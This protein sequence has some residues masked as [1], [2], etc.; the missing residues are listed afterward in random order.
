MEEDNEITVDVKGKVC[1]IPVLETAKAA[2][3]AKPGQVI[4]VIAT[5]PA[6]K[7]DLINWA[8]VTN[9]ELL[10]LDE[11]DGVITVRIRIKGK[12]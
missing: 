12:Q 5:D 6:A 10:N 11:S 1:P 2:R 3:L 9:N 4:K 7:Q 8:R